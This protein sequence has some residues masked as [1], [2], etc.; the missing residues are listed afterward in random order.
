M[1]KTLVFVVLFIVFILIYFF[2]MNFFS[3]FTIAG[4]KP[5]L[6]II[7]ILVMGL[8]TGRTIGIATGIIAGLLLDFFIGKSVGITAIM[9]GI[10]G[11]LGGYLDKKF[12]KDSRI[13]M[14]LMVILTTFIYELGQYGINIIMN[15]M[16]LELWAFSKTLFVE[17]IYNVILT[18]IFHPLIKKAG[19]YMENIFKTKNILTRYF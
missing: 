7:L 14:I 10:V 9:L 17:I 12:S 13:T 3:W 18:I 6:F 1:K 19:Y 16:P 5:N 11:F 15:K 8:F 4:V 2:Q